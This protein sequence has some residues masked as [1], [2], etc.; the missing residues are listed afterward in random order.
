MSKK[1][2]CKFYCLPL[3]VIF[4]ISACSN[5]NFGGGAK[6]QNQELKN[7]GLE[8]TIADQSIVL[9][10]SAPD[11]GDLSSLKVSTVELINGLMV[12]I[13]D[14]AGT[15]L[16]EIRYFTAESPSPMRI[17]LRLSQY[18]PY[19]LHFEHE[20][21]LEG[22]VDG[23][24][25]EQNI[26]QELPTPLLLDSEV[27]GL[28]IAAPET[29]IDSSSVSLY[30][31]YLPGIYFVAPTGLTQ[32]KNIENLLVITF[33]EFPTTSLSSIIESEMD[34]VNLVNM[35]GLSLEDIS[36]FQYLADNQ[37][38]DPNALLP[39]GEKTIQE[40]YNEM[41]ERIIKRVI[42]V[43]RII[44]Q[45]CGSP[46]LEEKI[47]SMDPAPGT[48]VNPIKDNVY[49]YRCEEVS[50]EE[51]KVINISFSPDV[52]ICSIPEELPGVDVVVVIDT[53]G[54]M[55][56]DGIAAAKSSAVEFIHRLE[57]DRDM[58][59]LV[60]FNS[61][62]SVL[63]AVTNEFSAVSG[64]IS[65]LEANGG[66]AIDTGLVAGFQVL[67]ASSRSNVP[68]VLVLLSDGGSDP[69]AALAAADLIKSNGVNI[70]TVGVGDADRGLLARI[71]NTS[72]D[73]LFSGTREELTEKFDEAFQLTKRPI[74][75]QNLTIRFKVN[76]HNYDF[77]NNLLSGG[78][79]QPAYGVIEWKYAGVMEG[80]TFEQQL[81]LRPLNAQN[82]SFG[83]LE[84]S[85]DQ[86]ADGSLEVL[87]V[88]TVTE[89]ETRLITV[90]QDV[91][92]KGI[93]K[94]GT[95]EEYE[96]QKFIVDTG[97]S[98]LFSVEVE[99]AGSQLSPEIV[100]GN[101]IDYLRPLYSTKINGKNI[102]LFYLEDP[103]LYWFYLQ[104]NGPED[105]G[106]FSL[107]ILDGETATLTPIHLDS[108]PV[109]S[110]I[111]P[112]QTV[113]YDL[114]DIEGN[115]Y[116]SV[117]ATPQEGS[118]QPYF[119][120]VSL[121][122]EYSNSMYQKDL[123]TQQDPIYVEVFKLVGEGPYRLIARSY[124]NENDIQF[125][126]EVRKGDSLGKDQGEVSIKQEIN[127]NVPK[128]KAYYW[129]FQ[130]N[131]GE[132]IDLYLSKNEDDYLEY[133]ILGEDGAYLAGDSWYGQESSRES[134]PIEIDLDGPY[135]IAIT[136]GGYVDV[137]ISFRLEM[138]DL[139]SAVIAPITPDQA[140]T[141]PLVN[142]REDLWSFSG[143]AGDPITVRVLTSI[144]EATVYFE[145]IGPAGSRI[146]YSSSNQGN[147]QLGP[148]A[149]PQS[150][151]Y[152]L[153]VTTNT[154]QQGE[155]EISLNPSNPSASFTSQIQNNPATSSN[156]PT[157]SANILLYEDSG[158]LSPWIGET[159]DAMGMHYTNVT[160]G[161][162]GDLI[163][164]LTSNSD[165]D[166]IIISAESKDGGGLQGEVWSPVISQALD[167][168]AALI[169]D[170]WNLDQISNGK[171]AGLLSACGVEFQR[172]L[173]KD[174]SIFNLAPDHPVF[175]EPN[176]NIS[177]LNYSNY[178]IRQAGDMI[179]LTPDSKAIMLAGLN[180]SLSD[181][182]GVIATCL[183][184][185]M[186]IQTFSNHDYNEDTIKDLWENYINYVLSNRN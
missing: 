166:L 159:L 171:V 79:L 36:N 15:Y 2:L 78:A 88:E 71:A 62:A 162:I 6:V 128:D 154:P 174:L 137:D 131:R 90:K 56:G 19:S 117:L 52:S 20:I 113:V 132:V 96:T 160:P 45:P 76:S 16:P 73:F 103:K 26:F 121:D 27:H 168:Q 109:R 93:I 30:R 67:Q 140:L 94:T 57:Q 59:G 119:S 107:D 135:T 83:Q 123:G 5:L 21:A 185:R 38:I 115:G 54:S 165:W 163:S 23:K 58:V 156:Q 112:E 87:P 4:V 167:N 55:Q 99:G 180:E 100:S 148:I 145:L 32:F 108:G 126:L 183:D 48:D 110:L 33:L 151:D 102:S 124:D 89:A 169:V 85:Y 40:S 53:S 61:G 69:A 14:S 146:L 65:G 150:G 13:Y 11:G 134:G 158:E 68:K 95:L 31:T 12:F 136:G 43:V 101:G 47:F 49:L 18:S 35:V 44:D 141:A 147:G 10:I 64:M 92:R 98:G 178:W 105:T 106:D 70:I 42:N 144:E 86:C 182:N 9:N 129:T 133:M 41:Q 84:I 152:I 125:D 50:Q 75:A 186:I 138:L 7:N 3:I 184:G 104:S 29:L 155:Y 127:A 81:V 157:L 77:V 22:L 63:S 111:P 8:L 173:P 72:Q 172:D 116:I 177:L 51:L 176:D 17:L 39:F 66:T 175:N 24:V 114:Q 142:N 34:S 153:S 60:E 122:G 120:L 164:Q 28:L 37:D 74:V 25:L 118:S 149:L 97:I 130:G 179:R 161:A 181:K 80:Q 46:D 91:I 170:I 143:I 82:D 139:P 1:F